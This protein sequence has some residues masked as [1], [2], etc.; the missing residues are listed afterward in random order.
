MNFKSINWEVVANELL[1]ELKTIFYAVGQMLSFILW[2]LVALVVLRSYGI[3]F[4]KTMTF[5]V[6]LGGLGSFYHARR[7]TEKVRA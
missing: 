2:V 6:I 4:H 7:T 1:E 3:G 5:W